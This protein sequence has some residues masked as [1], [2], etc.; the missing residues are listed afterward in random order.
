MGNRRETRKEAQGMPLI[1]LAGLPNPLFKFVAN[2]LEESVTPK[3]KVI[4]EASGGE[5]RALY[6]AQTVATLLKAVSEYAVR[7]ARAQEM[8]PSP[9]QILLAYIP[10]PDDEKLLSEFD[11]FIFPIRLTRL[12]EYDAYGRQYRHNRQES[13][14]YVLPSIQA[15]LLSFMEV[16]RRLSSP[17]LREPLLLPPRNFHVSNTERVEAIFMN[18]RRGELSWGTPLTN[19]QA[20][21]VT[22]DDLEKHVRPG[23]HK[24]VLRDYRDLLFPHDYTNHGFSREIPSDAS[25]QDRKHFMRSSFRFGVPLRD[26]YHH[27]VQYSGK[28]LGGQTFECC[29]K[30][31]VS[32]NVAYANVY[33]NDFVRPG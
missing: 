16:K 2:A 8:P 13:Q 27:D 4:A 14:S 10:S 26:G 20:Q 30:G 18:L 6:R 1:L 23:A 7:Q 29:V 17:N 31:S 33:P 9:T 24:Q 25:S 19:I 5:D 11:F 12:A 28:G 15:A 32:L 21:K 22:H 3:T